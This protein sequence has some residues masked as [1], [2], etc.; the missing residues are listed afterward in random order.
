MRIV[1]IGFAF[2]M[3]LGTSV[4]AEAAGARRPVRC[5]V[6][7]A[8]PEVPGPVC[9][10]LRARRGL[11]PRRACRLIGGM[12]IGRGDCSVAACRPD[13]GGPGMMGRPS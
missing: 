13:A 2:V 11:A 9:V 3:A 10:Q 6:D 4:V 8:I 5:C 7:F 1:G 12:P